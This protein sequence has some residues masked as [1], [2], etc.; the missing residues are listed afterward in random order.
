MASYTK[1]WKNCSTCEFWTGPRKPNSFRNGVDVD[2]SAKGTCTG[3]TW[4]RMP[5]TATQN[6]SDWHPWGVFR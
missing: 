4:N 6:C 3:K 5:R 2:A 1:T